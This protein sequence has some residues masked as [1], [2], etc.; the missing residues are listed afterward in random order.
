MK[1]DNKIPYED[2]Y[3]NAFVVL[4]FFDMPIHIID[5]KGILI[6]VNE[7]W[8]KVYGFT[9]T[10]P[11]GESIEEVLKNQLK[12]YMSIENVNNISDHNSYKYHNS[13]EISSQSVALKV[14]SEKRKISMV[15]N[16]YENNQQLVTSTPIFDDN[17]ELIYV[18]TLV[19]DLTKIT[20]LKDKL[21]LEIQKNKILED[22]ISFYK[23]FREQSKLIGDTNSM[24]KI[25][26]LIPVV[27][28]TDATILIMG[29]SG[30]GKEVVAKEI[31]S[32]SDRK[33]KPFIAVNC[34]AIPENLLESEMFGYEKGAFTGA[35]KCKEGLFELANGGTILLDEISTMPLSL[36]P[37]LL[38]VL[39]ER[40]F[41]RVGGVKKIP[42]DVRVIAAT[43]ENLLDLVKDGGFRADLYYRLNVIPISIPPLRERKQ[44]IK[45]LCIE[46][47]EEF[48]GKYK[49]NKVLSEQALAN[50]EGYEWLGNIRELKN[51]IERLVIIGDKDLISAKAVNQI[52]QPDEMTQSYEDRDWVDFEKVDSLK[53]AV[54]DFERKII[55]EALKKYKNTYATAEAL[56]TTQPTIVRKAKALGIEKEWD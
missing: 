2:K 44:D 34:S 19:Q 55:K 51:V 18:F 3:L 27:A 50:L 9:N 21:E 53:E 1:E 37:K 28:K 52:L 11:V 43:N 10:H 56:K 14:L 38:R 46:F 39:Q 15:T 12:Y 6:Y 40:E 42:L 36:Q 49:R 7:P 35:V 47:I 16:N 22:K 5:S 32:K 24:R 17:N 48:N 20:D 31:F 23:V 25:K 33:N 30:V 8:T 13:N 4:N 54:R 45:L 26:D 29:E 41:N